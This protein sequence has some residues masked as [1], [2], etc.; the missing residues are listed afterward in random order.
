MI[1]MKTPD[2]RG[3]F[4]RNFHLLHRKIEQGQMHFSANVV[5][6]LDGLERVRILPNGR[7]DFLSVDESARLQAN[8]MNNFPDVPEEPALSAPSSDPLAGQPSL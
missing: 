8:T 4:E 7:V 2:T 6:T 3:E 5:H 1:A